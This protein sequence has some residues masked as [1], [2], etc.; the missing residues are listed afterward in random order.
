VTG[1]ETK[2]VPCV[3]QMNQFNTCLLIVLYAHFLWR[4]AFWSLGL[5]PPRSVR[6]AFG[7]CLFGLPSKTKYL[8][9]SGVDVICW[10]IWISRN[11]LVFDKKTPC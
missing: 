3:T 10:A 1:L 9:I 11:D 6:H 5:N 7:N 8:V 4:L 2:S